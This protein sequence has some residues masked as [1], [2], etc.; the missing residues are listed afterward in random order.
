LR[1]TSPS[2]TPRAVIAA[3]LTAVAVVGAVWL[4]VRLGS[5]LIALFVALLLSA[6]F[7]PVVERLEPRLRSRTAAAAVVHFSLVALVLGFAVL[8]LP[9]MLEEASGFV[10]ALPEIYA[11]LRAKL[12]AADSETL[13]KIA[14]AL[15]VTLD[16]SSAPALD[17]G[18]MVGM[19]RHAASAMFTTIAVLALSFYWTVHREASFRQMM[20]LIPLDHR[21]TI[22]AF[23]DES[24]LKLA[25]YVRGQIML[26]VAVGVLAFIAYT[27]IGLPNAAA[28]AGL[29]GLFEA[30][31]MIGPLLG[32][33]PAALV[34]VAI[35]PELALWVGLAT[36]VIQLAENYLLA[37]R[38]MDRVVG[39]SPLVTILAIA[40]FGYT[41]GVIGAVLAIPI[42]AVAQLLLDRIL[43]T[44]HT[45]QVPTGR[46]QASVLHYAAQDLAHDIRKQVRD[47]AARVG[48]S[49]DAV[50]DELEAIAG[51]L[52]RLVQDVA[53]PPPPEA[54]T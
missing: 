43:T 13:N 33:I 14:S 20:L 7:H 39:V 8:A 12:L 16:S 53:P 40:G 28:L 17:T 1:I 18:S 46:D 4:G 48:E 37:P 35:E 41:L 25:A 27:I 15:P 50:E 51:D 52:D 32:A 45:P 23:A 26:C 54:A 31:P 6:A 34:A 5:V 11:S 44:A 29:A 19:A 49:V 24:S 42:A 2:V 22:E 36:L 21:T 30:V 38:I 10:A 9:F 47:K 3:T